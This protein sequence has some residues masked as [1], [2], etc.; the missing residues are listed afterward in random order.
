MKRSVMMSVQY[1]ND[2]HGEKRRAGTTVATRE[3]MTADT[4]TFVG[5]G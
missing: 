5:T 3:D 1:G 2:A 4:A